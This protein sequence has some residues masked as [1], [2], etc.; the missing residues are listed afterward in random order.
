MPLPVG[1]CVGPYELLAPIGIGGMGEVYRAR[2]SRI[3]REV[4]IKFPADS[5]VGRFDLEVRAVAALNHPNICTLYDVGPNYLVTEL[6]EGETLRGWLMRRPSVEQLL[7]VA[8]QILEGLAA[9]HRAG[10]VHRDLKPQN[11]MVRTD[12]YVKVLDFGLAKRIAQS[13]FPGDSDPTAEVT[14]RG[15]IVGT[16][17]YMSPEQIQG[18]DVDER[19]D[20]FAFGIIL[21]E[22]LTGAHPWP[23]AS[24]VDTL[25]AIL[26]DEPPTDLI[27]SAMPTDVISVIRKL[28]RKNPYDRYNSADAVLI[29]LR[30]HHELDVP[31]PEVVCASAALASIAVLPFVILGEAGDQ[32]ALSLGFA[33]AL[34]TIL[35]NLDTIAVAPTSAII[36]Y[37]AGA[38]PG[39][40]CRDLGVRYALQGSVQSSGA[41]RRISLQL[42]D[43]TS[44]R[45][46]LAEKHDFRLE[47]VFDVQDEIGRRVVR[48]LERR[49]PG[50]V[51]KS[52]DRYSSNPEAY[53]E[54]MAGL[55]GSYTNTLEELQTAAGH[56]MRAV[57]RDPVFAL[58]HAWLS[59]VSMQ[60]YNQFDSAPLWLQRSEDHCERALQLDP[61]LPEAHWAKA[62]I[63][64]SP[65]KNFQHAEAIAA[66]ERVLAAQPNFDRAHNRM[67]AICYHIGRL[68]EARIAHDLA[69]RSNPRN[70]SY[71][72][73]FI[74]IC[75]GDFLR[76][77]ELGEAW[78]REQPGN[79]FAMWYHAQPPLLLG[80]L[81]VAATRLTAALK[82]YTNEPLIL[83]LQ[84]VL[85]ACRGERDPA[86]ACVR[87]ALE[88]PHLFGHT[89]HTLEQIAWAYSM[90]GDTNNAMAWL[91]RSIETGNPCW[92]FFRIHPHLEHVRGEPRFTQLMAELERKYTALPIRRL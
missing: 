54:L 84:A 33:D 5:F 58:A 46:T 82:R 51:S 87:Q 83:S 64:W 14:L 8:R 69:M 4:A 91:E 66:L 30:G 32:Q 43:T 67:A 41:Q 24:T 60:I 38:D 40:V 85:H 59:H 34:I 20:L 73:E 72:L 70:R 76:A 65:A 57:E 45:M 12:G 52:R 31:Q 63:L 61:D 21:Y 17:A 15:H 88:A 62:V 19:S 28:L 79:R 53:D 1:T 23:R 18:H 2:D 47:N 44:A 37:A 77:E 48:S 68:E 25:H 39:R 16:T 35:G 71:N 6:V 26:H 86:L 13:P 74:S 7:A 90:L 49:L 42:F 10:F 81:D 56:L 50:T 55:R 29:A 27:P 78:I 75:R 3:G 36:H 11:I 89:H 92:P 9:A 22:M 80:Q